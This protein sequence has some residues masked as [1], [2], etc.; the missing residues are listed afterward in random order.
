MS[1]EHKV[2]LPP[3]E[4]LKMLDKV[5][6][7]FCL[8]KWLQV[9]LNLHTGTNSSCCLTPP[10][11]I[12]LDKVISDQSEF[13]NTKEN[14]EDRQGLL[15]GKKVASCQFCWG[16][17]TKST[18]ETSER[19]Y[20][21]ASPWANTH[22]DN[23]LKVGSQGK[24]NPS[25][26]EVS[27][28]SKCNLKCAYCSPQTSSSI[29]HEVKKFGPYTDSSSLNDIREINKNFEFSEL[30]DKNPYIPE[31]YKWFNQISKGL[32]VL[33]F[34]GG[35]PLLHENV[36]KV[37][38]ILKSQGHPSLV[39][40]V[41]SNLSL[42]KTVIER[43]V[44]AI[45]EIPAE[46][47]KGLK[48]ITSL[49]TGFEESAYVRNGL[50]IEFFKA[51]V[52]SI[53]KSL[54]KVEF[55]FTVT[56]NIFSIFNFEELI[57][58]TLGLKRQYKEYD[59]ILL[60]IYPLISPYHLSLKILPDQFESNFLRIHKKLLNTKISENEPYGFNDYEIDSFKKIVEF[61]KDKYPKSLRHKLQRDFYYFVKDF[62]F[63]KGSNVLKTFP[64]LK[65]FVE[66]CLQN[67][68]DDYQRVL[69][70]TPATLDEFKALVMFYQRETSFSNEQREQVL[71][72]MGECLNRLS[73]K[74][75]HDVFAFTNDIYKLDNKEKVFNVIIQQIFAS[76]NETFS[77]PEVL[78]SFFSS[79]NN[80]AKT[81]SRENLIE[82]VMAKMFHTEMN[83]FSNPKNVWSLFDLI[84][85]ISDELKLKL[86]LEIT[87][88]L[89]GKMTESILTENELVWAWIKFINFLD[90]EE[91]EVWDYIS[92]A[93]E[94][95]G[96]I[97]K[98]LKVYK[99]NDP[100][101]WINRYAGNNQK[102]WLYEVMSREDERLFVEFTKRVEIDREG[103]IEILWFFLNSSTQRDELLKILQNSANDANKVAALVFLKRHK[104]L[105]KVALMRLALVKNILK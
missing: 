103:F 74:S 99:W 62:D 29:Y 31:F 47:Y 84:G 77:Q 92:Q 96:Q 63:R 72:K 57:D 80:M 64:E 105:N 86:R 91:N 73:A 20:K 42:P 53:L 2:G 71:S 35:E 41:N 81:Q 83:V 40:E 26:L 11:K 17:E 98:L 30:E 88:K 76:Q 19:V 21:S 34:T 32:D 3:G 61:Y 39:I 18:K 28:S 101:L 68:Q 95:T 55:R 16:Q 66:S 79:I 102:D 100:K 10:S 37:L 48:I 1:K 85:E 70:S 54:P 6:P 69:L 22:L 82:N 94:K 97:N 33:R 14:H 52:D 9:T 24:M 58:Y 8:A 15:D 38:Q 51:N 4:A 59:K 75:L 25:Y 67:V 87:D 60:S 93:L 7:T 5:S 43:F 89:F 12:E 44:N 45:S 65:V 46:N 49:D 104:S 90:Y 56:F 27:F 13:H 23:V 50:N 78:W 36:F